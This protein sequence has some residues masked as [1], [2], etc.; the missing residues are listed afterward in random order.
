MLDLNVAAYQRKEHKKQQVAI[1]K[2]ERRFLRHWEE[3]R[4]GSRLGYY[5]L[6]IVIWF[7][8]SMLCLF[9][10]FNSFV[11]IKKNG[12]DK[13]YMMTAASVVMSIIITHYTYWKNEKKF[14]SIIRREMESSSDNEQLTMNN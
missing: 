7:F 1:N 12:I 10:I 4:K 13:L 3:Q 6:F 11:Q 5:A 2:D 8:T 9:F 14:K